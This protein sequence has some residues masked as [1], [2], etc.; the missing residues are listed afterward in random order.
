MKEGYVEKSGETTEQDM[1][2]INRYTR[3]ELTAE[4]VYTFS[5]VLCDNEIDRDYE[6]FTTEALEKLAVLFVGRTGIFDHQNSSA[7]Q[8][9]RI[10]SCRVERPE[11]KTT[12]FGEPYARLTAKAYLPR[13]GVQEDL[14]LQLDAG[15]KKEVSVG[16]SV[17]S[18]RCSVCGEEVRRGTCRHQKGKVYGGRVC[19]HILEEPSDAY[20][21][22]FVAVPAQREAGVIKHYL[23]ESG[24]A[25]TL[26][27]SQVC[28]LRGHLEDLEKR[29]GMGDEYRDNL[30]REVV[31]LSG[32]L[33]PG[34]ALPVM[35]R[36]VQRMTL[37]E[38]K[39][40]H[41]AYSQKMEETFPVSPQLAGRDRSRRAEC[42][43]SFQI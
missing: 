43:R 5:V 18:V 6:R 2:L 14:I 21:W 9:A 42:D 27:E 36:V 20:E 19:H 15:I 34:I 28:K 11:G 31:R 38:L 4:E 29:A 41:K 37:D 22:S 13:G 8:A 12:S 10:Y 1:E 33:Q 25:C 16:C 32:I 26:T 23:P 7:N 24:K 35:E 30:R 17:G 3:R 39:A 40:F